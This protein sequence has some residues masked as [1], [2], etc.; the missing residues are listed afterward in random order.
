MLWLLHKFSTSFLRPPL[1]LCLFDG[2]IDRST[3]TFGEPC[4]WSL[5]LL[6]LLRR[7]RLRPSILLLL[8]V[9]IFTML[10]FKQ[11]TQ[12]ILLNRTI[13][14]TKFTQSAKWR[15]R[16][17]KNSERKKSS[18][19]VAHIASKSNWIFFYKC[20]HTWECSCVC[21]E[22]HSIWLYSFCCLFCANLL[23]STL[24]T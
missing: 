2:G 3:E 7:L 5:L 18:N 9:L 24:W 21:R 8:F 12:N 6:L 13:N 10:K 22:S 11:H 1:Y 17:E 23:R 20:V 4:T 19:V 14:H 16:R 15:K